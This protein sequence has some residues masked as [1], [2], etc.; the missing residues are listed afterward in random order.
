M[1]HLISPHCGNGQKGRDSVM[2]HL[3]NSLA[4]EGWS[5]SNLGG[6]K[7]KDT[8]TPRAYIF[9][10]HNSNIYTLTGNLQIV[11]LTKSLCRR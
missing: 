10:G 8:V 1:S 9:S 11:S 5:D 3:E 7:V 4:L 6:L 2:D